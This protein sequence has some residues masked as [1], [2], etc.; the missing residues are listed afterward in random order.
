M[1]TTGYLILQ[2]WLVALPFEHFVRNL[3]AAKKAECRWSR[4]SNASSYIY[5]Q[6]GMQRYT[7]EKKKQHLSTNCD[8]VLLS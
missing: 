8:S 5:L 2:P 4:P 6:S 3:G 1:H 7:K